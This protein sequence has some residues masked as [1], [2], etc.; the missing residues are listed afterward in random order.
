MTGN[1]DRPPL[2]RWRVDEVL[3]AAKPEMLWGLPAIA[4]ALSVSVDTA[5]RWSRD[6]EVPIYQ[7]PGAGQHFAMRSELVAWLKRRAA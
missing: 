4:E 1:D 3:G 2:D 7:P 6:P 5:R